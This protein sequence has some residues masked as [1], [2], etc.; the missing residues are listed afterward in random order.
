MQ[1]LWVDIEYTVGQMDVQ[2]EVT[3]CRC[4]QKKVNLFDMSLIN[5]NQPAFHLCMSKKKEY[6][7]KNVIEMFWH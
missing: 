1:G 4:A 2:I 6:Q 3:V 5:E 7:K